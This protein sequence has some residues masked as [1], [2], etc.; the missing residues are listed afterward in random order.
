MAT[1]ARKYCPHCGKQYQNYSTYT[2]DMTVKEGCPIITCP[3][4]GHP[5]LD[6]DIKE[7]AFYQHQ[8]KKTQPWQILIAP[9][10]PFGFS[11]I[12]LWIL[13]IAYANST[14]IYIS[15]IPFAFYAYLVYIGLKKRD[16]IDTDI[17]KEYKESQERVSD[18]EYIIQLIELGYK[19]PT[20]FL[21]EKYPDLVYYKRRR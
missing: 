4:C 1:Y 21:E 9:L 6:K 10:F 2:K 8:P 17:I 14:C 20:S 15:L 5:F 3:Y 7:P 18:R 16:E 13:A 11:C 12:L 19:I